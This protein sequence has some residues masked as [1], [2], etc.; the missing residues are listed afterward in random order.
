MSWG[1]HRYAELMERDGEACPDCGASPWFM[2]HAVDPIDGKNGTLK[3]PED[4]TATGC[5]L[6]PREWKAHCEASS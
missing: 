4:R 6:P 3:H 2:G 5:N 1:S